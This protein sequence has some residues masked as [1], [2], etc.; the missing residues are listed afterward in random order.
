MWRWMILTGLG[1]ETR[2]RKPLPASSAISHF[3][4]FFLSSASSRVKARS[5]WI[6]PEHL[7]PELLAGTATFPLPACPVPAPSAVTAGHVASPSGEQ[8]RSE[9]SIRQS[10]AAT[11]WNV[12]KAARRLGV[13]R[14]TLYKRIHQLGITRP[15]E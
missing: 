4:S 6:R 11:G 3:S 9:T 12:A 2:R 14:T 15:A 10:L 8:G 1:E 5:G 13:S 7:P